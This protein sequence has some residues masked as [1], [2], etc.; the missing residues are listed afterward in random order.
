MDEPR[1]MGSWRAKLEE[2]FGI[3]V[4]SLVLLR[5]GLGLM[6]LLDLATRLPMFEASYTDAGAVPRAVITGSAAQVA[7]P[8]HMLSGETSVQVALFAAAAIAALLMML[9][10]WT[11]F[12]TVVSWV[13]LT[14]LHVRN[15]FVMNFGD[16][17]FRLALFWCMFLPLG[18]AFSLDARRRPDRERP[19]RVY[20]I[21]SAALLIQIAFVYFFTAILK[22]GS[23]WHVTGDATYYA[24]NLD[25]GAR[26]LAVFLREHSDFLKVITFAT[27]IL[28]YFGPVALFSPVRTGPVRTAVVGLL[29]LFHSGIGF[30]LTM[31]VF[32]WIDCVVVLVFLPAWFWKHAAR[33]P[34]LTRLAAADGASTLRPSGLAGRG[35][36]ALAG[37]FLLY[38]CVHNVMGIRAAVPLNDPF[39][40]A[41]HWLRI[42]QRWAMFSPNAPRN[43]G[44]FVVPGFLANGE[45]VDLSELGPEL[46]WRKPELLSSTH[47][48]FRWGRYLWQMRRAGDN[49]SVRRYYADWL[50]RSWNASHPEQEKLLGLE[51]FFVRELTSP[52]GKPQRPPE[53]QKLLRHACGARPIAEPD[54]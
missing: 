9:G 45:K 39:T 16:D 5:I 49:E 20:S 29:V 25:W 6:L 54:S 44:W 53:R 37:L 34:V 51:I 7:M 36:D 8:L 35:L 46:D 31:G 41:G 43:D 2:L 13:L 1:S 28:E 38:V 48:S 50:C 4:R 19:G 18:A 47:E 14:S 27:L 22:S 10:L 42:N 23:D 33:V 17:V 3:D 12:A 40:R 52:P 21:A 26:S 11:R 15:P 32:P 30:S 24:L